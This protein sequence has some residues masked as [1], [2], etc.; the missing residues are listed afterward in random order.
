LRVNLWEK[1]NL[2]DCHAI[3]TYAAFRRQQKW[4]LFH[5]WQEKT[6]SSVSTVSTW[7]R[8]KPERL[9]RIQDLQDFVAKH[10][11]ILLHFWHEFAP[12]LA[13]VDLSSVARCGRK[14][15]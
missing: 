15:P 14:K 7:G 12:L 11:W 13:R 10:A 2:S 1:K 9:P 5:I 4:V 6:L 8:K 3:T